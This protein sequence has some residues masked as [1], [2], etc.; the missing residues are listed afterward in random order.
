MKMNMK[1]ILLSV[2][3]L[4]IFVPTLVFASFDTNL[5]SGSKGVAVSQLQTFL[6][7]QGMYSGSI[8]GT[9][10]SSTTKAVAKFQRVW[11]IK[12]ASGS[13]NSITRIQA[14]KLISTVAGCASM[15]GYS[16]ITGAL[17][18]TPSSASPTP[19]N[20]NTPTVAGCTST[21]GYSSTTGISCNGKTISV[22]N[23]PITQQQTANVPPPIPAGTLCNGKYY[24]ACSTGNDFICPSG[25]GGAFCQLPSKTTPPAN[26]QKPVVVIPPTPT[27]I[28]LPTLIK[29]WS[30]Y[31]VYVTCTYS[32]R[33]IIQ[34]GSGLISYSAQNNDAI[35]ITNKH[36]LLNQYGYGPDYCSVKVPDDGTIYTV[37]NGNNY[38]RTVSYTDAGTIEITNPD[39]YLKNLITST[40]GLNLKLCANSPSIGD[41]IVILGYPSIGSQSGI[42]ATEGIISGF[43]GDYYITSAKVE[44]GNSGGVALDEKNDCELGMPTWAQ[45]GSVES[46]ARILKWQATN[47]R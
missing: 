30:P 31:V 7:S 28:D 25:G 44:H 47:P 33:S 41:S 35:L 1:K 13:F 34:T 20:S 23:T 26:E 11:S 8:T 39:S 45:T 2:L 4:S 37:S 43:D 27:S 29:E 3:A 14:N 36:I 5:S 15:F 12:P 19:S 18:Y 38:I 16:T 6:T 40:S 17:C 10:G 32:T 21:A 46:L 22:S 42:T 24:S 9:Y